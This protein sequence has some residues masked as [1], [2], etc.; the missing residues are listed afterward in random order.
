MDEQVHVLPS[1]ANLGQNNTKP[2]TRTKNYYCPRGVGVDCIEVNNNDEPHL[3]T[4]PR[5]KRTT[6]GRAYT[7][8][9]RA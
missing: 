8:L 1:H 9:C 2:W 3:D 6:K 5:T 7:V 4:D